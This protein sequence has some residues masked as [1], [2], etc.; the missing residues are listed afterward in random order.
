MRAFGF[1]PLALNYL[2]VQS[3]E[4]IY[5]CCYFLLLF[6]NA[7]SINVHGSLKYYAGELHLWENGESTKI[8]DD[9]IFLV[10]NFSNGERIQKMIIGTNND[11]VPAAEATAA[12]PW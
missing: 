5:L 11:S 10:P 9:V 1:C 3:Q 6:L 12:S 8:D 2:C 7:M 4:L